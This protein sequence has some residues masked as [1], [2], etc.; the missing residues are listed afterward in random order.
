MRARSGDET[1]VDRAR[2]T[3]GKM[4]EPEEGGGITGA[5]RYTSIYYEEQVLSKHPEAID[6]VWIERVVTQPHR[7]A[8]NERNGTVSYW[9]YIHELGKC[10]LVVLRE[11]DGTLINRFPDSNETRRWLRG[12]GQP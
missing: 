9:A 8:V 4:G 2:E 5:G 12:E 11:R 3:A 10:I 7:V 1:L 6:D